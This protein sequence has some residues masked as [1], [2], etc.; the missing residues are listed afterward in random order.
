ML[1]EVCR[2]E[3]KKKTTSF[4]FHNDVDRFGNDGYIL[5]YVFVAYKSR[6]V[7]G[8]GEGESEIPLPSLKFELKLPSGQFDDTLVIK[9]AKLIFSVFIIRD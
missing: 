5:Y 1:T 9:W 3:K 8:G 4:Y 2:G 6:T 7:D